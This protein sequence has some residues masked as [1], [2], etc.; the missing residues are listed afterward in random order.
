MASKS[1]ESIIVK[2]NFEN[3]S[4]CQ[5]ITT[6]EKQNS[7]TT[8]KPSYNLNIDD[9]NKDGKEN[10]IKFH[11]PTPSFGSTSLKLEHMK[12]KAVFEIKNLNV[13]KNDKNTNLKKLNN[14][15]LKTN[16]Y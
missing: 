6:N 2:L 8:R 9:I 5:N 7:E 10:G 4:E 16:K 15:L 13:K 1:C 12:E 11:I 3:S 14:N